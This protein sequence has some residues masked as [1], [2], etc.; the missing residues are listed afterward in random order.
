MANRIF[1]IIGWVGTALVFAAVA[2]WV[3]GRTRALPASLDTYRYYLALGG[4]ACMVVYMASQW[5]DVASFFGAA[6]RATGRWRRRACSSCSAS[7]SP[8]TTSANSRT[9]AGI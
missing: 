8:S 7:W 1:S 5:R 4:L 2:I 6:R 3:T 9:S